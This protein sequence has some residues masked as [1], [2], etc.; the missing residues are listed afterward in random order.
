VQTDM[1]TPISCC[2]HTKWPSGTADGPWGL[3]KKGNT[4]NNSLTLEKENETRI[5]TSERTETRKAEL[6]TVASDCH[7]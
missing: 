3:H 2:D 1:N 7:S 4:V 5:G 6:C